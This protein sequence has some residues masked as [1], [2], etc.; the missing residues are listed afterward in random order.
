MNRNFISNSNFVLRK[1]LNSKDNLDIL[2]DFIETFL[3]IEIQEIKLN[4]YLKNKEKYLPPEEKFGIADVRIKLKNEEE[5]NVGIQWIDGYYAQN[6]IL[7]YYAQIHANQLE[8]DKNRNFVKTITIN[9]LD[10]EY[11]KSPNYHQKKQIET[12]EDENQKKEKL[13]FHILE[14]PKFNEDIITNHINKKEAW[15][16]YLKGDRVD[17][18]NKVIKKYNA[19]GKLDSLLKEYWENEKM[20]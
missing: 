12:N 9:I 3:N 5:L 6:K 7:L 4:P 17:L 20:E 10:F 2:Q 14:L 18:T 19:I 1:I 16:I 11:F 8:H 15:M 13:E